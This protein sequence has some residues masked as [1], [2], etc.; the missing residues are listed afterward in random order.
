MPE[1]LTAGDVGI[2]IVIDAGGYDL[3]GSTCTLIACPGSDPNTVGSGLRLTPVVVVDGGFY[4]VYTTTGADFTVP[5]PWLVQLESQL[6]PV[7]A[8][9]A[10]ATIFVNPKL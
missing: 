10:P 4:A 8:T 9:S 6:G 3:G 2:A 5:G 1:P 7:T